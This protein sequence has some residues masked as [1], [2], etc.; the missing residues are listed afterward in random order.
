MPDPDE[1]FD[2]VWG[3][4]A[5]FGIVVVGLLTLGLL[6]SLGVTR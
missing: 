1:D 4:I 5:V 3:F 6:N 2:V